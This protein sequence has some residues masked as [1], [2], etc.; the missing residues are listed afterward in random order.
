VTSRTVGWLLASVLVTSGCVGTGVFVTSVQPTPAALGAVIDVSARPAVTREPELSRYVV[1]MPKTS[2]RR[3]DPQPCTRTERI[4]AMTFNIHHAERDGR[5]DLEQIARE[6]EAIDPDVVALNEVDRHRTRS[7]NIDEPAWLAERLGMTPL[8]GA[9]L[10]WSGGEQGEYGN[11]LLTKLPVVE[12]ANHLLPNRPGH[13]QRGLLLSTL[14]LNGIQF[15]VGA[16]HF[17][18]RP[19]APRLIQA[20]ATLDLLAGASSPKLLMGDLNEDSR[21]PAL[22][23]LQGSLH[24]LW[25][26][27]G[28][29]FGRSFPSWGPGHARIDYLLGDSGVTAVESGVA[30]SRVSDHRP[31]WAVL[32]V[33][34]DAM[35]RPPTLASSASARS[36]R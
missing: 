17:E 13:E 25:A 23:L 20:R 22:S 15:T 5:L 24:D 29:G 27:V 35:C 21:E 8:F 3:A 1:R 19:D 18:N 12:S 2:F 32:D 4:V 34:G 6:I 31:V 11:A 30:T 9:N 16:T 7:A 33:T 28:V 36:K 14:D 10:T 26:Q